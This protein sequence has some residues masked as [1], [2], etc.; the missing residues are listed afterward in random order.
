MTHPPPSPSQRLR[1]A[2]RTME[3]IDAA[4]PALARRLAAQLV[5]LRLATPAVADAAAAL[6]AAELRRPL[7]E[8]VL[9]VLNPPVAVLPV[10]DAS[11]AVTRRL[12]AADPRREPA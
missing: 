2:G 5:A 11:E 3:A 12:P 7:A 1:A 9:A 10:A 6:L 4:T 8:I